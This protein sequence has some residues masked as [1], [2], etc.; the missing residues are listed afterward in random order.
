[1]VTLKRT[2]KFMKVQKEEGGTGRNSLMK[3]SIR[4]LLSTP[5]SNEITSVSE[6]IHILIYVFRFKEYFLK[7]MNTLQIYIPDQ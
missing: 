1:M 6:N 7:Y 5:T 3:E 4:T 2:K